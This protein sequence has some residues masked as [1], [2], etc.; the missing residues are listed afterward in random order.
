MASSTVAMTYGTIFSF[1]CS[2]SCLPPYPVSQNA[3]LHNYSGSQVQQCLRNMVLLNQDNL[4]H[5]QVQN[6][7]KLH[8]L[9]ALQTH[10][11]FSIL[12][13]ILQSC[14]RQLALLSYST[15][16]KERWTENP[17]SL[18]NIKGEIYFAEIQY[19]LSRPAMNC[20][21]LFSTFQPISC[22]FYHSF[23]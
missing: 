6:D 12:L 5:M 14:S 3:D 21:I 8:P 20:L 23:M 4:K 10:S 2:H 18:A 19:I 22:I 15:L 9:V 11:V 1:L 13:V 17:D 16:P 7:W